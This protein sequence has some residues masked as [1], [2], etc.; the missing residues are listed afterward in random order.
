MVKIEPNDEERYEF[1]DAIKGGAVPR[2][3]IP[4]VDKGIQKKQ[5][6]GFKLDIQLKM[7]K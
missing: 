7:L 3:F 5:L 4:A 6:H 2:E 1:I